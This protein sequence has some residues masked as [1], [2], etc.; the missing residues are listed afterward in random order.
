MKMKLIDDYDEKRKKGY[1]VE[2]D[3]IMFSEKHGGNFKV[4]VIGM[5]KNPTWM[6]ITWL[7]KIPHDKW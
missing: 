4:R 3:K 1:V 7:I 2:V 5:W 6:A